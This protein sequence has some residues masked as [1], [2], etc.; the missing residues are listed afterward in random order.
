MAVN[1]RIATPEEGTLVA[2]IDGDKLHYALEGTLDKSFFSEGGKSGA[3]KQLRSLDHLTIRATDAVRD[4]LGHDSIPV[5]RVAAVY[6]SQKPA[7][8]QIAAAVDAKTASIFTKLIASGMDEDDAL[9]A[10]GLEIPPVMR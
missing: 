9:E 2:N 7:S 8:P 3:T 6:F 5:V 10:C 4:W 1:K